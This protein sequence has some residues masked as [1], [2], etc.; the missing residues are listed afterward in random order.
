MKKVLGKSDMHLSFSFQ[1]A[2][3]TLLFLTF[4]ISYD[5]ELYTYNCLS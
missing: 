1:Q 4:R 2:I 5:T 3:Q